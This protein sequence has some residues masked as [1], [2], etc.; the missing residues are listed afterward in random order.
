MMF[1]DALFIVKLNEQHIREMQTLL[2]ENLIDDDTEREFNKK[3]RLI[4]DDIKDIN[5]NF[6]CIGCGMT[7]TSQL[8]TLH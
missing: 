1:F 4:N 6:L 3:P 5:L 8:L 2:S 7:P